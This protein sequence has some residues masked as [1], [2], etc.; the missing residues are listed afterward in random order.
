MCAY[1]V[2]RGGVE[3]IWFLFRDEFHI[4]GSGELITK[5][6]GSERYGTGHIGDRPH[7]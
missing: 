7:F 2:V 1:V 4:D 3:E 6:M 5:I